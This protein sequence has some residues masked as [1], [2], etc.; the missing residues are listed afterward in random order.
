V[1]FLVECQLVIVGKVGR[2]DV[3]GMEQRRLTAR[4]V[5][6]V[7]KNSDSDSFVKAQ[8]VLITVNL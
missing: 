1:K 7:H 8:Y 2:T 5:Q 3:V 4:A 6:S